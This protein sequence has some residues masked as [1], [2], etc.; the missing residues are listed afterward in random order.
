MSEDNDTPA[1]GTSETTVT[2]DIVDFAFQPAEMEIVTG[3][4]VI[5]TNVGRQPYT[6]T[7]EDGSFDTAVLTS[8]MSASYTFAEPGPWPC[9][10]T[11]H[12]NTMQAVLVVT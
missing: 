7:A 10:C 8:D 9:A 2:V 1:G 4:T 5:W 12:E 11:L 6:A 3:T